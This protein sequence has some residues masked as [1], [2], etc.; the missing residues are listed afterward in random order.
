MVQV[1]PDSRVISSEGFNKYFM[2]ISCKLCRQSEMEKR[3]YCKDM[4]CRL[5]N[6][7]CFNTYVRRHSL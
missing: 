7:K 3:D 5:L 6:L 4:Y 1:R 2:L